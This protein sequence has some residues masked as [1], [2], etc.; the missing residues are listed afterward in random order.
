LTGLLARALSPNP[1]LFWFLVG[2]P[3]LIQASQEGWLAIVAFL[4]GY[5]ATIVGSNVGLAVVLHRW[6][7]K[8]SDRVYRGVLLVTSLILAAYGLVLLGRSR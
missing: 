5:Y 7:G 3:L 1:Y 4:V 6:I 2:G 8:V